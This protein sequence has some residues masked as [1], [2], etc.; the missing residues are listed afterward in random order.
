MINVSFA[1][2][3]PASHPVIAGAFSYRVWE[4]GV[5]VR[6]RGWGAALAYLR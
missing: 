6:A 1:G 3:I 2:V 5:N 4:Y